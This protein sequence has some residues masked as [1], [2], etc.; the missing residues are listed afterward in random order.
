MTLKST[1]DNTGTRVTGKP[2][3]KMPLLLVADDN[4]DN[5][6]T[7]K[8]RLLREGYADIIEAADGNEALALLKSRDIDLVLLD[9]LMPEMDGYQVLEEM[10]RDSRLRNIPVI[11]NSAV[12]EIESVVRCIEA[13]A[14]DYL[15]KPYN[16]VLLRARVRAS[17]EKKRLRDETLQQLGIIRRV[18][19][20]YVP[21]TV[22]EA[23]VSGRGELEPKHT[24]ATIM[25]TDIA[26]FTRIAETMQPEHVVG[27]LNEYFAA[28]IEPI[29]ACGGVVN[30][31][32]GDAMLVTFNVPIAD[33]R[34]ADK[35]VLTATGMQ[36]IL[37]DR[38]F[39]GVSL[40]TRMGISSGKV[41]AGNVG[42]GERINYTVYGNAVNLAARLERL[43]KEYDSKVLI[44]HDTVQLLS[45]SYPLDAIGQATIR[46][47]SSQTRIYRLLDSP[48]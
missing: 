9:V 47:K 2:A 7:L 35:A 21:E 17:L 16:A 22:V 4:E 38:K 43:N 11:M 36:Q 40:R 18:F 42:S 12:T 1:S 8:Q 33:S 10:R 25:Y 5:R 39:A 30:Q 15:A 26:D 13:G 45:G 14:D 32:Q 46:G 27:M 34:H 41:F 31:F 44:S 23:I 37:G 48:A 20:K 6:Y 28:V 19:G 29:T 24:D 3:A